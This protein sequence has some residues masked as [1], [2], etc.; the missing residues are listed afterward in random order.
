MI[1]EFYFNSFNDGHDDDYDNN[2][3]QGKIIPI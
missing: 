3:D 1:N 2:N